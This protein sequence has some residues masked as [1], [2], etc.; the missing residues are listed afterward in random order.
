MSYLARNI[1]VCQQPTNLPLTLGSSS[2]NRQTVLSLSG[3]NFEV[4][5]PDI[6]EKSFRSND[7]N[8]LPV[9][10]AK[11]KATAILG[12]VSEDREP[13]ILLT[14]D[15]IVL[16]QDEIREKPMNEHQATYFL[17]SYSNHEVHT[18]SA[19]VATHYPSGETEVTK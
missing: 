11:A 14:A 7:P 15:Q 12:R 1:V 4:A 13:F 2:S 18:I 5:V 8:L 17:S 19:V 6:D 10:I 3:W 16:Y 9:I